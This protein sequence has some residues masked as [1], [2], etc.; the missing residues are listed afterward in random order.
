VRLAGFRVDLSSFA[1][2]S[3]RALAYIKS[4][5]TPVR[6][7]EVEAAAVEASAINTAAEEKCMSAVLFSGVI[8]LWR[9]I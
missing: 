2:L 3:A 1:S 5:L 7:T 6:W 4:V 9:G 8:E